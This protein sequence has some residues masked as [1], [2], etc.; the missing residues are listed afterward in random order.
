MR[1]LRIVHLI[2]TVALLAAAAPSF[3]GLNRWTGSG[4]EDPSITSLITDPADPRIV[5]AGTEGGGVFRSTTGGEPHWEPAS[6]DLSDPVVTALAIDPAS[7]LYAGTFTGRLFR[8]VNRGQSWSE[9]EKPSSGAV[10][11]VAIDSQ[12][13]RIYIGTETGLFMSEDEGRSWRSIPELAQEILSVAVSP[14]GAVYVTRRYDHGLSVST[15]GGESWHLISS[16]FARVL[17]A[18]PLS[19]TIYA[20][21]F[22]SLVQA[23]DDNGKTWRALPNPG[24]ASITKLLAD[25]SRL[26]AV[27]SHGLFEHL[28]GTSTWTSVGVL[29]QPVTAVALL[30]STPRNIYAGTRAGILVALDGS[31]DWQRANT[32]MNAAGGRRLA[33][34]GSDQVFPFPPAPPFLIHVDDDAAPGGNGTAGFPFNNLPQAVAAAHSISGPVAV[35]V[36]P[37]DY[38]LRRTLVIDRSLVLQGSTEQVRGKGQWPTGEVVPGT[39]TRVFASN[40]A[41]TQLVLVDRGNGTVLRDI[42]VSGFVFE[43]TATGISLLLNRVQRYVILDNVFRAPANFALQSVASSG[44]VTGNHFSGVGTGAIF[45][46]GYPQSPSDVVF[47]GNRAVSNTIGG[48]LLNGASIN[49]PELGDELTAVVQGND[50]SENVGTQG[51]GLRAFILRRD[52][53]APGDSQSS[54]NI[55]AVVQ[56][57]R[58]VGN[59]V[60][61]FIDAG[62]PFRQVGTTC[63][64]RVYS[65]T[66]DLQ[67]AGNSLSGSL[68]TSGLVTFTRNT[69]ALTPAM[70]P[71]WQYLHGATFTIEDEDGVLANAWIDHPAT[72]PFLGPCPADAKH[73]ALDNVLIYNGHELPNGRNF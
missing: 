64:S 13:G 32:G 57:N 22:R 69:A 53:G 63:D 12:R 34:I 35:N 43:G 9:V 39:A 73:E 31:S 11:Q 61:V 6:A 59:R 24:S 48:V 37:G 1:N 42:A 36:A 8:S 19:S 49:I 15:D 58:I 68:L 56:G 21:A 5:Y 30:S 3:G 62:F 46:G 10:S 52:L 26:Y 20:A 2:V 40:P 67:F 28:L 72:D 23:S 38:A 25:G 27:T 60:G 16:S 7:V 4:P 70:L 18:D 66:I 55:F 17:A 54:A 65:G 51:F 14:D 71:Q 33:A 41:L 44:V 45:A 29:T 50:L 47:Q